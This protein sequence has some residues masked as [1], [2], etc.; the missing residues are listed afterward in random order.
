MGEDITWVVRV[1]INMTLGQ[2]K[3]SLWDSVQSMRVLH[4]LGRLKG[5]RLGAVLGIPVHVALA[6]VPWY[7][8][9]L[10]LRAAATICCRTI[11]FAAISLGELV[12]FCSFVCLSV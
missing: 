10:L 5:L 1:V 12:F 4:S 9:V 2:S 3:T 8:A 11:I 6:F 7:P